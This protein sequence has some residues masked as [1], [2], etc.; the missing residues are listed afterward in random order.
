MNTIETGVIADEHTASSK[1]HCGSDLEK[2]AGALDEQGKFVS[3][4]EDQ[5]IKKINH[6]WIGSRKKEKKVECKGGRDKSTSDRM[7]LTDFSIKFRVRR[8][9]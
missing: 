5:V 4:D 3:L 8:R 1:L 7:R 9:R 2:T 6:N